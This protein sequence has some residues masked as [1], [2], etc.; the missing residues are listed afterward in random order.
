MPTSQEVDYD[1]AHT[2]T[3][4][5]GGMPP[6][7]QTIKKPDGSKVGSPYTIESFTENDVGQYFCIATNP[8]NGEVATQSAIYSLPD[9][10]VSVAPTAASIEKSS[11]SVHSFNCSVGGIP[12]YETIKW[13]HKNPC[14][15]E[16]TEILGT[17][18]GFSLSNPEV[19]TVIPKLVV[20]FLSGDY[21]CE[22]ERYSLKYRGSA[23]LT[24]TS[25][26]DSVTIN[27]N[28]TVSF[29]C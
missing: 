1:T 21:I 23:S 17:E 15:E 29:E 19:L 12:T 4:T 20:N 13:F 9:L 11:T 5:A 28:L 10:Y 18:S 8:A 7:V 27:P 6:P 24:V 3:C 14:S 22:V 26:T 25:L 2:I 16:E